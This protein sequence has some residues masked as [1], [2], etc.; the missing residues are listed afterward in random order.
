MKSKK[1]DS[2]TFFAAGA[3]FAK[4]GATWTVIGVT[5]SRFTDEVKLPG[6]SGMKEESESPQH[7]LAR[8]LLN[9]TGVSV[10]NSSEAFCDRSYASHTKYFFLVTEWRVSNITPVFTTLP[11][12]TSHVFPDIDQAD[13]RREPDGDYIWARPVPLEVFMRWCFANHRE[14]FI[15]AANAYLKYLSGPEQESFGTV[16]HRLDILRD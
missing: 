1:K 16:L 7:C 15:Q 8:E 5:S 12:A 11:T 6:G 14:G 2:S 4:I 10:I 9:E 3:M 13:W